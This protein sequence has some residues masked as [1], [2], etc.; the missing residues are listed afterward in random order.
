MP[1]RHDHTSRGIGP[2]PRINLV[3][4]VV[5]TFAVSAPAGDVKYAALDEM[6]CQSRNVVHVGRLRCRHED[7]VHLTGVD[8][9]APQRETVNVS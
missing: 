1:R 7:R 4:H 8:H 3:E 2:V 6:L 5:N 9:G